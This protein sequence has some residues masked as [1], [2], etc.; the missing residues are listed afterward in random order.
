M[1]RVD[2]VFGV[3]DGTAVASLAAT[4]VEDRFST[5]TDLRIP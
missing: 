3:E 5:G 2:H 4:F 1:A